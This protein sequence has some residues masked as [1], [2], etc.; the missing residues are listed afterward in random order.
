VKERISEGSAANDGRQ[1]SEGSNGR[2]EGRKAS[3][4]A[5]RKARRKAM[6][7]GNE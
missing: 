4:K 6:S 1:K 2:K 5:R 7:E 3:R